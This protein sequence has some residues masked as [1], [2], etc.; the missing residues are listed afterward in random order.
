MK[1]EHASFEKVVSVYVA[2]STQMHTIIYPL[3]HS[4]DHCELCESVPLLGDFKPSTV[5]LNL[6]FGVKKLISSASRFFDVSP[7][8]R[9]CQHFRALQGSTSFF[10][11]GASKHMAVERHVEVVLIFAWLPNAFNTH[12]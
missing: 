12:C 6:L 10:S 3:C 9:F 2:G 7:K 4:Y 11:I 5:R 1:H 8:L